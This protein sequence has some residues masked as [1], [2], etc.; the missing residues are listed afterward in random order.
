MVFTQMKHQANK[1]VDV[2]NRAGFESAAIHG[3]KSQGARTR[4]LDG[5]KSGKVRVLV[6]TD[7]AARGIDV[8]DVTHVI[9]FDLPVEAETYV[10][11]IGRTARAGASGD[12]VSFCSPPEISY[13]REIEKLIGRDIPVDLEHPHHSE[14]ARNSR[15]KPPAQGGG[16]G[17][18][19]G[20]GRGGPRSGNRNRRRR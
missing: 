5:F 20:G 13:L 19:G 6:A 12:A 2:L 3:N 11:R 8:D 9:N 18:R 15:E 4:A 14:A 7:V 17:R 1:V 10:H 16:G